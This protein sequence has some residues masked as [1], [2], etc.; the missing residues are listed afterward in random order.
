MMIMVIPH[1]EA[2]ENHH[3][4]TCLAEGQGFLHPLDLET[5]ISVLVFV[6]LLWTL[7]TLVS[8]SH[9]MPKSLFSCS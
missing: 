9:G 5:Q 7:Y 1:G 6:I 3:D 2:P 4:L 8:N